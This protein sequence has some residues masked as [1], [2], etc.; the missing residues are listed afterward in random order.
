MTKNLQVKM[1]SAYYQNDKP[2]GL[3]VTLAFDHADIGVDFCRVMVPALAEYDKLGLDRVR[4]ELARIAEIRRVREPNRADTAHT[5]MCVYWMQEREHLVADEYNGTL[6]ACTFD[7]P[8]GSTLA[9][10]DLNPVTVDLAA[11]ANVDLTRIIKASHPLDA[12]LP[13]TVRTVVDHARE[14]ARRRPR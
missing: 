7:G 2:G 6:F 8:A 4:S 5:I 13:K 14:A 1:I 11:E 3:G 9:F 10:S 12:G